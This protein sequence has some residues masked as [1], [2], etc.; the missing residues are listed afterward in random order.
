[1]YMRGELFVMSLS[2]HNMSNSSICHVGITERKKVKC[3]HVVV[4]Y[5]NDH[6]KIR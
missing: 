3:E 2:L 1:M 5:N 4:T 6:K